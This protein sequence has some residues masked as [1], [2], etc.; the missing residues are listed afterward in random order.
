[1]KG[2]G[3]SLSD[4]F[5]LMGQGHEELFASIQDVWEILP[6]IAGYL[7]KYRPKGSKG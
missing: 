1:M 2:L 7:K 4:Y 5:D 3:S 6:A